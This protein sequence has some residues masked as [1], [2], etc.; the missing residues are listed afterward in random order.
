MKL[1]GLVPNSYKHVYVSD[2]YVSTI[3]LPI[4]ECINRSQTHECRIGNEAAQ[5]LSVNI[6]F[7][8]SARCLCSADHSHDTVPLINSLQI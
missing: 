4:W 6:C 1:R 8:F 5:F 2:L 3:G 7:E